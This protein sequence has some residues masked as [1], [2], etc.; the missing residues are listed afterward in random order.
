MNDLNRYITKTRKIIDGRLEDLTPP[1]L[2]ELTVGG[3]KLRSLL[4]CLVYDSL[5]GYKTP[6]YRRK[7][8]VDLACS[9]EV[10]HNVTLAADDIIDQDDMRRGKPS[11]HTLKGFSIAFL[12][13]LS[14][15]SFP[16]QIVAP[17]GVKY[18]EA[19]S[20]VQQDMCFGVLKEITKDLPATRIYEIVNDKK[21]GSLF[22]LS[23]RFG[24]MAANATDEVVDEMTAFG[25]HL[26]RAYQIADDIEDFIDVVS[27]K[28]TPDAITGTEFLLLRG[29]KI[30]EILKEWG[31][32]IAGGKPDLTKVAQAQQLFKLYELLATLTRRLDIEIERAFDSISGY[33]ERDVLKKYLRVCIPE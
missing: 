31:G 22:A 24:A 5:T 7:R 26:G 18:V 6:S 29:L 4:C 11:L 13:V 16:Y 8:A 15:I 17:Y 3:K 14:G 28:K 27:Q 1:E 10:V 12:E 9:V 25:L 30:D 23:A 21:T 20:K 2:Y 32:D 19:V 33:R